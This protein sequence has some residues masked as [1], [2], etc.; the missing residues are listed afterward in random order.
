[1]I[2]KLFRQMLVTQIVSSMTVTLCMLIDSIMI[3][4][5]LGVDAMTAYGLSTPLLLVFAAL[6]SMISA[7][8]QVLCGRSMGLGDKDGT[9]SCYTVSVALAGGISLVG[10]GLVLVLLGPLTTLLGAGR[11]GPNNPVFGLTKDY[12]F[13]FILGA[14][15]FLCA[16]IMVPYMQLSGSRIRLVAA[17]IAMT[18]SDVV[19]DLLNVFVFHGGT[20]GMGI[21]SSLSYYIAFFIGAGYF[22]RKDCMFRLRPRLIRGS[23]IRELIGCG[24]PTVINQVSM[25]LLVFL[26]NR[27]LLAVEGNLAVAAYS[28][29]STV[30]NLC[31]CF[32]AGVGSVAMM[33]GAI[34]Y[35][36]RD[37]TSIRELVRV[38][39][40]YAVVL[41]VAVTL[42]VLLAASPLIALF[43]G[44]NVDAKVLA[45]A[46]LRLFVLSMLPS[47]LNTTFKSYYQGVNRLR[48]TECISVLQNLVF[49]ILFA[50][51]LSRFLGVN[52]VWLG[53]VCGETAALLAFSCIVWKRSRR[54][55]LSADAYSMLPA[56]FGTAP[57]L[58]FERTVLTVQEATETSQALCDFCLDRGMDRRTAMLI[59]LCVEEMTVNIIEHGFTKDNLDHNVDVRV[60]LEE[61]SRVIRIRDNCVHFDPTNYL[62]LHQSDDPAAHIGLRMVMGMVKE[63]GY[64]NSLG[65]N[66]LTLVL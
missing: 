12:L 51:V 10:L 11:P 65:L 59:G 13:G 38:M 6:G 62:A 26:L 48:L 47:S 19:F 33:L 23:V 30:G 24:V 2:K 46:G 21:A 66:N 56:D 44:S 34:F 16:Q 54:V 49:P 53:F 43:L 4:R 57:E 18:V 8:V 17:V 60:V 7:G 31:Y 37:R 15:A 5:F 27:L 35:A 52:G 29:I 64:V 58:C 28:V 63:A 25:V 40:R 50:F 3:G 45:V 36:D 14:P 61:D 20:L 1:M 39:T 55:S 9:D 42:V 41:D 22:L 32:G